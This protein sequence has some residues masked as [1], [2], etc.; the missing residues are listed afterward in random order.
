MSELVRVQKFL[1]DRGMCSRREAEEWIRNGRV[2]VN[3][4]TAELGC[5]VDPEVDQISVKNKK[6]PQAPKRKI[7]L[8]MN[9]PKG[10]LCTNH[11]PNAVL[12]VFSILPK[13]Y[14]FDRLFCAG[15]LD[16]DSE[17]MLILTNDGDL[18]NRITHPSGGV[19]K[20]YRVKLQKPFDPAIIPKLLK[21]VID[22]GEHLFARKI[23]PATVGA[24][25][26]HRV[27]VHLDQGRKR[28]IRRLFEAFGYHVKKLKRFQMGQLKMK[29]LGPGAVKPLTEKE[30]ESLFV[31][32][33]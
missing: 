23:I 17:G 1:A 26:D 15:R 11:D 8:V 5:K 33:D 16:K 4:V 30:I 27:E 21:G 6:I 32:K 18:A 7:T 12:T 25:A 14:R 9:K 22:E 29:G 31:H 3:G 20:R 2:K 13:D 28:E 24:E 19:V 10:T